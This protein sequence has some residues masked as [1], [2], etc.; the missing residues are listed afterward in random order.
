L[1]NFD[2]TYKPNTSNMK[3]FDVLLSDYAYYHH[4]ITAVPIS[5]DQIQFFATHRLCL[6]LEWLVSMA[7][8][9]AAQLRA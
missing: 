5:I 3:R 9:G 7:N 2:Y 1:F 4:T 6:V 8:N